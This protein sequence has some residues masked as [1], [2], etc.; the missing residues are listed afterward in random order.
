[1]LHKIVILPLVLIATV[2]MGAKAASL[3]DLNDLQNPEVKDLFEK[4]LS[5]FN[6]HESHAEKMVRALTD[7]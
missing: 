1:M 2:S 7:S 3:G 4:A 6:A 5:T